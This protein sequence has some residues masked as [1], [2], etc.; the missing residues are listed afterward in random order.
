MLTPKVIALHNCRLPYTLSL[1]HVNHH[2]SPLIYSSFKMTD[3]AVQVDFNSIDLPIAYACQELLKNNFVSTIE[4]IFTYDLV[5][6]S[7]LDEKTARAQIESNLLK[8]LASSFGLLNGDACE[9]PPLEGLY[10]LKA[11]IE[12]IE[13][14][15]SIGGKWCA[16]ES[17]IARG[18]SLI[19]C[20]NYALHLQQIALTQN[21]A[22][23]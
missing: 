9:S 21:L 23:S 11:S 3:P 10:V 15:T 6:P 14:T 20:F 7:E 12:P 1:E 13:N 8:E 19:E 16:T 2:H 18:V 17:V 22:S 4:V 5:L